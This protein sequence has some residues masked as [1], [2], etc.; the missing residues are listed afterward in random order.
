M[1]EGLGLD[2]GARAVTE[3][4]RLFRRT[5]ATW[6]SDLLVLRRSTGGMPM[7]LSNVRAEVTFTGGFSHSGRPTAS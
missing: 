7:S 4:R 5:M 1:T 6:V 3:A 2:D